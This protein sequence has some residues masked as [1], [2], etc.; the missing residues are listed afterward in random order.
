M[1]PRDFILEWREQAPW[2]QDF[3]VEQD[4]IISRALVDIFRIRCCTML[5][6]SEAERLSTSST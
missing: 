6:R 4:L 3:Q 2:P 1:I 5:S